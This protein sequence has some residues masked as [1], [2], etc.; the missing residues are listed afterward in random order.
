MASDAMNKKNQLTAGG[1][2]SLGATTGDNSG[3]GVLTDIKN[4]FAN[5][6]PNIQQKG[7][8]GSIAQGVVD[9]ATLSTNAS[10]GYI[11]GAK[12]FGSDSI[13]G[14]KSV[15]FGKSLDNTNTDPTPTTVLVQDNLTGPQTQVPAFK[16]TPV[17]TPLQE[18]ASYQRIG[19]TTG[20]SNGQGGNASI[21][22]D[23][24]FSAD[25]TNSLNNTLAFN[26]KQSTKDMFARDA[27]NTADQNAKYGNGLES[28]QDKLRSFYT[29][30]L[31][32]EAS[33]PFKRTALIN[34]Y[35]DAL[36]GLDNG[37]TA[38][39]NQAI[40]AQKLGFTQQSKTTDQNI[41]AQKLINNNK[42]NALKL[43][44][45]SNKS[46]IPNP[47][48]NYQVYKQHGLTPS[49]GDLPALLSPEDLK[50]YGEASPEDKVALLDSRFG[51]SARDE[52]LGQQQ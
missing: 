36:Q 33:Q 49:L 9:A 19:G 50:S 16:P 10:K 1:S 6:I 43:I 11:D 35:V 48:F 25:Q 24:G 14:A 8:L 31:Q 45:E 17:Q 20:F 15:L 38:K 46:G 30:Q 2:G 47:A 5:T 51:K 23:K 37:N 22:S 7:L 4:R 42:D 32:Q 29:Q 44:T 26:A 39:S 28:P 40:E 52:L 18:P 34:H 41:E 12:K 13:Q 27:Q 3:T 21:T